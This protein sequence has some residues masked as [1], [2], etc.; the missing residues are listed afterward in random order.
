MSNPEEL[1]A[2]VC[3][4]FSESRPT[5]ISRCDLKL[6]S[7]RYTNKHTHRSTNFIASGQQEAEEE[8]WAVFLL[9]RRLQC[10][11]V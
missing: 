1:I 4:L 10:F 6:I 11:Q 7:S 5:P 2:E 3:I 8:L 9:S